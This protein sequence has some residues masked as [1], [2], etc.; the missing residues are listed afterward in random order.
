LLSSVDEQR[1]G[2][3]SIVEWNRIVIELGVLADFVGRDDG[4]FGF[5]VILNAS[6]AVIR[7]DLNGR[8]GFELR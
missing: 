8:C 6:I 2:G 5:L 1:R 7:A 4:G 3:D